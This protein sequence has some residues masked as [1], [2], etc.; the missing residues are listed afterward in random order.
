[1]PPTRADSRTSTAPGRHRRLRA[2]APLFLALATTGLVACTGAPSSAPTPTAT[3]GSTPTSPE[4]SVVQT[5]SATAPSASETSSNSTPLTA[6]SLVQPTLTSEQ[7]EAYTAAMGAV[8]AYVNTVNQAFA[9]PGQDWST[10][11]AEVAADPLLSELKDQ[12]ETNAKNGDRITGSA[13]LDYSVPMAGPVEVQLEPGDQSV[14]H[15]FV[16]LAL[17]VDVSDQRF[18]DASGQAT[19][20]YDKYPRIPTTVKAAE[21]PNGRW[22]VGFYDRDLTQTC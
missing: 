1:M 12:L 22:L 9:D 11:L 16:T 17:C 6:S 13:S 19:T 7:T 10:K 4:T 21:F 2:I 8:A 5:S 14:D 20:V 15:S 18:V 3:A